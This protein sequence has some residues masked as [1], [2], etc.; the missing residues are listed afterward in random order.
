MGAGD[1]T[2][3][4]IAETCWRIPCQHRSAWTFATEL[5]PWTET[6]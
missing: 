5:R 6:W 2:G 1:A 3:G 4:A